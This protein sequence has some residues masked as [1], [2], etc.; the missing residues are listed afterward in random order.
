M[1]KNKKIRNRIIIISLIL[2]TLLMLLRYFILNWADIRVELR[3]FSAREVYN[4]YWKLETGFIL[5]DDFHYVPFGENLICMHFVEN[6]SVDPRRIDIKNVSDV[7]YKFRDVFLEENKEKYG[8]CALCISFY[9]SP[10]DYLCKLYYHEGNIYIDNVG[11]LISIDDVA[12]QLPETVGIETDF[13]LYRDLNSVKNFKELRYLRDCSVIS[14]KDYNSYIFPET[15]E[16]SW[17]AHEELSFSDEEKD[18]IL[19]YF[20]DCVFN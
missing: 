13:M 6:G 4:K 11:W 15:T 5:S 17:Q 10:G 8:N 14:E 9:N 19:S 2:L 1:R 7:L 3:V 16:E 12:E 18:I 20:P